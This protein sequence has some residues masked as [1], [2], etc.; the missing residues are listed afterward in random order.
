MTS[1]TNP[2]PAP[3]A[4]RVR[5][6]IAKRHGVFDPEAHAIKGALERLGHAEALGALEMSR[7]FTLELR[8]PSAQGALTRARQICEQLLVQ[9]VLET[10]EVALA[11]EERK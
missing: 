10:Y 9:P 5:V 3:R 11:P 1:K 6:T 7:V 4:H 2:E 8:D